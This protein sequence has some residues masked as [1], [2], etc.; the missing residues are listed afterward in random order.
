MRPAAD[1]VEQFRLRQC[2]P[3]RSRRAIGLE[4]GD[5]GGNRP[6]VIPFSVSIRWIAL[7]RYKR[8]GIE[9]RA[10]E[11]H[12]VPGIADPLRAVRSDRRTR[13]YQ[14]VIGG[15]CAKAGRACMKPMPSP[16]H[17]I[18]I[19]AAKEEGRL[20]RGCRSNGASIAMKA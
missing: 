9:R 6:V 14:P 7:K 10:H 19:A 20:S 8:G 1:R 4:A 16:G 15:R 2:R 3:A 5:L 18:F 11:A 17:G 12:R 13:R